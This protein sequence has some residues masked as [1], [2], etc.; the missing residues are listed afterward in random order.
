MADY[1]NHDTT[2][3]T[4][5]ASGT[6]GSTGVYGLSCPYRLPCGICTYLREECMKNYEGL[7]LVDA[8]DKVVRWDIK[9]TDYTKIK[10]K[11]E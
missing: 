11:P 2:T 7:V 8:H 9:T 1:M 5:T 4:N 3:G 10:N 6:G